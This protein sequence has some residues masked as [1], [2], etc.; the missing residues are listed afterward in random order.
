MII[1]YRHEFVFIKTKKTAGSSIEHYLFPY[2][3]PDDVCSGSSLDGTPSLNPIKMKKGHVGW[4]WLAENRP[5]EWRK[6][7]SFAVV[8]NPWDT[9]V[10]AYF[11]FRHHA[12]I[13]GMAPE[14]FGDFAEWIHSSGPCGLN[15]WS[16]F[17]N[18]VAPV[19]DKV[20]RYETLHQE[21]ATVPVPYA[22]ELLTVFKKSGMRESRDY[23]QY[24][25]DQS[26]QRVH[27]LFGQVI[28]YFG[29]EF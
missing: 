29:Y 6:F 18:N 7:F 2:L 15:P 1:S 23:R 4:R 8:R 11:W 17:A 19:V 14:Q 24:Y 9:A 10:S 16:L 20:L 28:D 5:R 22:G 26:K 25:D 12:D 13:Q 27:E 21:L 3:G